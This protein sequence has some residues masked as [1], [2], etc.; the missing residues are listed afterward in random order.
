MNYCYMQA[1]QWFPFLSTQ[2]P[3]R[4][5]RTVWTSV[6][7]ANLAIRYNWKVTGARLTS[8][9]FG[10]ALHVRY[11]PSDRRLS[12]KLV[13]TLADKECLVISAKDPYGRILGFLHR[14]CY[15]FF[16]VAPQR[17]EIGDYPENGYSDF[18]WILVIYGDN[19]LK[20]IRHGGILRKQPYA[21]KIMKRE[22]QT[23]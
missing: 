20:D 5:P 1:F 6:T 21:C 10:I 12:T 9:D 23:Y 18:N 11:R 14:S 17:K 22:T 13:P 7:I 15:Y 4:D 3:S 2:Q 19:R 8:A 16:Q